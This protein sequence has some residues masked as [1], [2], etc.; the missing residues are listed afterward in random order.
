MLWKLLVTSMRP[1]GRLLWG[2]ILFQLAQSIANLYLPSLN[3]D[4]INKGVA[5]VDAKGLP[6]PDIAHIWHDGGIMLALSFLQIVCAIAA[7]YFGAKLAMK[8]GRDLRAKIFGRVGS[9][10]ENEV[11]KF[12]APSL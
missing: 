10:S 2:V 11:Q 4:L 3:A 1:Y 9:F 12:G 8:V 6:D 7:V 5:R